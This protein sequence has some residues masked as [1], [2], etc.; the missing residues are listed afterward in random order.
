MGLVCE[1]GF[2]WNKQPSQNKILKQT[3]IIYVVALLKNYLYEV[4]KFKSIVDLAKWYFVITFY[5]E[6]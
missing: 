1:K 5:F 6:N 3:R 4:N 2:E